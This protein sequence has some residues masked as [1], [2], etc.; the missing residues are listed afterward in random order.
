MSE[1]EIDVMIDY[2]REQLHRLKWLK[3]SLKA[4]D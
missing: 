3:R 1:A 2:H 4:E